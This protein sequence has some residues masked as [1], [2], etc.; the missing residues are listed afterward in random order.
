M[1]EI[2]RQGVRALTA[3]LLTIAIVGVAA[4]AASAKSGA[5][6]SLPGHPLRP[7]GHSR[8][9][10]RADGLG[11][12]PGRGR[13]GSAVDDRETGRQELDRRRPGADRAR[14]RPVQVGEDRP[15]LDRP[16]AGPELPLDRSCTSR[17]GSAPAVTGDG[18][19]RQ[20]R[21]WSA[22]RSSVR[23]PS[24][25]A[26]TSPTPQVRP[27]LRA[28]R[29]RV[30][31]PLSERLLHQ[32]RSGT[33][34]GQR[35]ALEPE[36]DAGQQPRRHVNPAEINTSDGFSP[37]APVVTRV[38]GMDTPEAFANTGRCR[39]PIWASTSTRTQP[40]VVI[41]ADTGKRQL[42]WTELDSNA[43]ARARPTC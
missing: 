3:A 10:R 24:R 34:T 25:S 14:S 9:H 8:L 12:G 18:R 31:V 21:R 27:D 40:I 30:P 7:A 35:L 20:R 16:F 37:G 33:D 13:W 29:G 5:A 26:S 41:D 32:R 38:P 22:I 28:R 15:R 36:L 2:G 19:R 1:R 43:L 23:G 17:R 4:P 11:R 42:I 6:R 39:S